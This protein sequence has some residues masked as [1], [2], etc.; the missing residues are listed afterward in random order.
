MKLPYL[1]VAAA[2][3]VPMSAFAQAAKPCEEL[4]SEIARKMDAN[5][6]KSYSLDV[7]E[8]DKDAQGKVVGTCDGGT[9]KIVYT[10]TTDTASSPQ[11]PTAPAVKEVSKQ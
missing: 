4:K 9:K 1:I 8:K 11:A 10:R 6:V 5:G 2:L 7:V 3:V